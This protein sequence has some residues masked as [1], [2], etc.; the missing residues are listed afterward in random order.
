MA[1]IGVPCNAPSSARPGLVNPDVN[2]RVPVAASAK[3]RASGY[4]LRRKMTKIIFFGDV[5]A[6]HNPRFLSS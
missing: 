6:V 2:S 5:P 4:K 3:V 1:I